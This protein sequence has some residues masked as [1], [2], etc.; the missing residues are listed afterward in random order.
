HCWSSNGRWMVFSSK[1][2]DG[3]L[4][5]PHFVYMDAGGHASKPFVLPQKDPHFYE[6][7]IKTYNIPELITGAVKADPKE[8]G[9]AVMSRDRVVK[10]GTTDGGKNVEKEQ[11]PEEGYSSFKE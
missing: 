2:I 4:A 6:Y 8:L 5:R 3:V 1:R 11:P 10:V 7:F 9:Q